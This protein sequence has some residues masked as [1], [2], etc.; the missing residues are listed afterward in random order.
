MNR[1]SF[2]D[3]HIYP[4][5]LAIFHFRVGENRYILPALA[6]F[7]DESVAPAEVEPESPTEVIIRVESY[8]TARGTHIPGKTWRLKYDK[9]REH[10]KVTA[11]L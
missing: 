6:E 7:S 3:T 1:I 9:N 4:G 11:K 2:H 8:I 10:W 5:C